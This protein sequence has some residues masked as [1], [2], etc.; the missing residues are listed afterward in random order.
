[1]IQK[2][3]SPKRGARLSLMTNICYFEFLSIIHFLFIFF[4]WKYYCDPGIHFP[5]WHFC[6]DLRVILQ[7][8]GLTR[9]CD[10]LTGLLEV[11]EIT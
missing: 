3:H 6:K 9:F 1:M 2:L 11:F 7:R 4:S 10:Q 5:L 8:E